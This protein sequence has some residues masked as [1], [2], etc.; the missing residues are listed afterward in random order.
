LRA[1]QLREMENY[2]KEIGVKIYFAN[3]YH[4]WERETN[5]NIMV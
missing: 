2:T 5:E 3:P 1:R 4:S